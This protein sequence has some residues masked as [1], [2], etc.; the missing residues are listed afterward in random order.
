M[1]LDPFSFAVS[2]ADS[3]TRRRSGA[4]ILRLRLSVW[5]RAK[6]TSDTGQNAIEPLAAFITAQ[7]RV[8]HN[9]YP[10][11]PDDDHLQKALCRCLPRR[12]NSA[13][14]AGTSFVPMTRPAS[15]RREWRATRYLCTYTIGRVIPWLIAGNAVRPSECTA[16]RCRDHQSGMPKTLVESTVAS[17]C[18]LA[19]SPPFRRGR[20]PPHPAA[21]DSKLR[22]GG[23]S[24]SLSW[25]MNARN[26]G[27][28]QARFRHQAACRNVDDLVI[29]KHDNAVVED[30]LRRKSLPYPRAR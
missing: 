1:S 23:V 26:S 5:S 27:R 16:H 7:H 20:R 10:A 3:H 8:A 12:F 24:P 22:K 19:A 30:S 17:A 29:A 28:L 18:E 13:F 15:T 14:G 11:G 21:A 9:C 2:C 4:A 25:S 6:P